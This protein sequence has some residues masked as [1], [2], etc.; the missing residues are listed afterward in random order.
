MDDRRRSRR[1]H[2]ARLATIYIIGALICGIAIGLVH[3]QSTF[4]V[5]VFVAL[6]VV[7][8]GYGLIHAMSTTSK[9]G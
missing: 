7:R 8:G 1:A 4:V 2:N 5:T 9:D 6:I 3:N